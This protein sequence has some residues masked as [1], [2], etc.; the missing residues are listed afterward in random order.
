M[1]LAIVSSVCVVMFRHQLG[2]IKTLKLQAALAQSSIERV[3]TSHPVPFGFLTLIQVFD[4]Q[5]TSLLS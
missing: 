3:R 1:A 2:D 5:E 4:G